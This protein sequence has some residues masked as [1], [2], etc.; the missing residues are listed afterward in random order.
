M[1]QNFSHQYYETFFLQTKPAG[2]VSIAGYAAPF[3]P[4]EANMQTSW[5][6][7]GAT[8]WSRD[9]IEK[10]QHPINFPTRWAVC[11][12]LIYSYPLGRKYRLMVAADANAYHNET[13]SKMSFRQGIFYG[14][15]GSD[16]ALPL[17]SPKSR[18]KNLGLHLDDDWGHYWQSRSRFVWQPSTPRIM[19]WW[20]R[21]ASARDSM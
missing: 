3:T 21:G 18:S 8:A 5:L 13:Y 15:S 2:H 14:V 16:H 1:R 17:C 10:H 12:D 7:G 20:D 19:F 6:L 11:E 9:I 4:T